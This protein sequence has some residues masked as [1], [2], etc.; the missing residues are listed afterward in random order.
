MSEEQNQEATVVAKDRVGVAVVGKNHVVVWPN[1]DKHQVV[2]VVGEE[3]YQVV[4]HKDQNVGEDVKEREE[5]TYDNPGLRQ[6][7]VACCCW[8]FPFR[9][10][11]LVETLCGAVH[12][13]V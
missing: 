7:A 13:F 3:Q 11:L 6:G 2:L 9:L 5:H 1:E 12:H 4:V 10:L 8:L